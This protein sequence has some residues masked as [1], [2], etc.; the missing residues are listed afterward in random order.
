MRCD[1]V[2]T[3]LAYLVPLNLFIVGT[4]TA[5]T[6][7]LKTKPSL[8]RISTFFEMRTFQVELQNSQ[9]CSLSNVCELNCWIF[10]LLNLDAHVFG[11]TLVRV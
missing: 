1:R 5:T 4:T 3:T 10:L 6:R 7:L 11:V 8:L 9:T 2:P